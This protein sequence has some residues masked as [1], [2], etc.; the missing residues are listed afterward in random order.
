MWRTETVII[1][2][3]YDSRPHQ[4]WLCDWQVSDW[5]TVSHGWQ[6]LADRCHQ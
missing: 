4:R 3:Y 2:W 5:R 1:A 6:W